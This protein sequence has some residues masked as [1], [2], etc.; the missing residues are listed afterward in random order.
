MHIHHTHTHTKTYCTVPSPS[1][2]RRHSRSPGLP[3]PS[4]SLCSPLTG[5][6]LSLSLVLSLVLGLVTVLILVRD[7]WPPRGGRKRGRTDRVEHSLGVLGVTDEETGETAV[8]GGFLD[9]DHG[10]GRVSAVRLKSQ[11]WVVFRGGSHAWRNGD[12]A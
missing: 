5:C 11:T 10:L 4:S 1:L 9:V 12:R 7:L 6:S 8:R 3:R 2:L